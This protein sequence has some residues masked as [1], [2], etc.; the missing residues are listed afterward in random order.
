MPEPDGIGRGGVEHR[1]QA[2][3]ARLVYLKAALRDAVPEKCQR[4][5]GRSVY[6]A[7]LRREFLRYLHLRSSVSRAIAAANLS[8]RATA[9]RAV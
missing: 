6:I 2:V 3:F 8:P 1:L 9:P 5:G 4:Y 7:H